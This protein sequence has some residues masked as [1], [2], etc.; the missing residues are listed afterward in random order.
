MNASLTN[1]SNTVDQKTDALAARS[2]TIEGRQTTQAA[3]L[4][5]LTHRVEDIEDNI[6]RLE[7]GGARIM[8]LTADHNLMKVGSY[9]GLRDTTFDQWSRKF[10]DYV[11]ALGR[12]WNEAEKLGRLKLLL[13]GTP[14]QLLDEL[15]AGERDTLEH[16]IT[17]LKAKIDSPQRRDLA[18]QNLA[19]C[20]QR[21]SEDI[22]T[23]TERLLPLINAAITDPDARRE[24]TVDLFLEKINEDIAFLVKLTGSQSSFDTAR[25]KALEIENM[26][27]HKKNNIVEGIK[28]IA[29]PS[30]TMSNPTPQPA[31]FP[32]GKFANWSPVDNRPNY[33]QPYERR[34]SFET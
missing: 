30:Q 1:V 34:V 9:T 22:Q 19:T 28:T 20:K 2:I 7:G 32:A 10:S 12:N 18:K 24:R 14:R 27:S 33:Q 15:A 26:L 3:D 29:A 23:F 5:T 25:T 11:E 8:T 17:N 13:D 6:Q 4:T 16:A 31:Q 21:A